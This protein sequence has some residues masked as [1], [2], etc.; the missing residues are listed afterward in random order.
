VTTTAVESITQSVATAREAF[1]SGRTK[2]LAWRRQQLQ[3]L[4]TM[5]DENSD[6]IEHAV[7]TDLGKHPIDAFLTE[8][9]SVKTETKHT[10]R[11]LRRWTCDKRVP[12]PFALQPAKSVIHREPLGCCLI[13]GPWNYPVHLVLMPLVGAL[14]AGNAV[15]VKP[16]E[17]APASSAIIAELLPKYL[18]PE[19]VQVIQGGV[20]ETTALLALQFDHIFYTGNGTVGRIVMEAA[21]KHLTPVTLELGGKSPVWVDESQPLEQTAAWLAWGKF[22][23]CG[24]TCVAP[25]Y[26]LTTPDVAPRLAEAV[27][28]ATHA[29]YGD[30]PKTSPAYG[31]I[32]NQRHTER[33]AKLLTSGTTALGGQIDVADRYVAPTVLTDVSLEDPVM[34]DEIF[35]PIL[36]IV[37]VTDH[38]DAIDIIRR[39]DK[40]LALYAFTRRPEVRAAF[41]ERTSSGSLIFNAVAVHLGVPNLPF[42][43][44]GP[45]GMGAYHGEASIRTFSHER[46]VLRRR[47]GPDLAAMARPPF[48]DRKEKLLRRG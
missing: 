35:G 39:R 47:R 42:G 21:A 2:D 12:T 3:G 37:T 31:R 1:A 24:Q 48:T 9:S 32:I 38:N 19:A 11:N 20:E 26:V 30:D 28:T 16:S 46:S 17:L 41:T 18:D 33:L 22:T 6:R 4:I 43:G 29:M 40:P 5:L 23:N 36:P 8:V 7:C 25:D 10:L 14:A 44:V 27:K 45:S 13:L 34:S 15:I